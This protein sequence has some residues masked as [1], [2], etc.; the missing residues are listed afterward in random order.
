MIIDSS[1]KEEKSR[2]IMKNLLAKLINFENLQNFLFDE[3]N[4]AE[5]SWTIVAEKII[6]YSR[7]DLKNQWNKILK[8]LNIDKK[9]ILIQDL[10]MINL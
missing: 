7:D 2:A 9:C 6:T 5:I 3:K 4:K 10:R 1:L 8:Y